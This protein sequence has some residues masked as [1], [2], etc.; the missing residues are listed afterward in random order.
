MRFGA[1]ADRRPDQVLVKD[2]DGRTLTF[3]VYRTQQVAKASCP[4]E[5]VYGNTSGPELRLITCGGVFD[6]E[7]GS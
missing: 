5:D 6:R 1:G 2:G 4:T 3:T 7:A